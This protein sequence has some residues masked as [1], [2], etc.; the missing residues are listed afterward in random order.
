M[1]KKEITKSILI[2]LGLA[3]VIGGLIVYKKDI[4]KDIEN[5]DLENTEKVENTDTV[6]EDKEV[7][8]DDKYLKNDTN[9]I[10]VN[11]DAKFNEY[12]NLAS[13][14]F[15]AA[16]YDEAIVNLNKALEYKNSDIVYGRISSAYSAKGDWQNAL[17]NIDKAINLNPSFTEYWTTKLT[18]LDDKMTTSFDGLKSVYESGLVKVDSRTKINLVTLFARIAENNQKIDEAIKAFTYAKE[19]YPEKSS[20]YQSEID[21]LNTLK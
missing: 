1:N 15:L 8:E 13:K 20:L 21:R 3:I 12:L 17:N 11:N 18:I 7:K 14:S 4:D 19:I 2:I 16:K 6:D 9:V 5:I 10:K